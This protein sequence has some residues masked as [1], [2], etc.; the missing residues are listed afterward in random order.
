VQEWI[1]QFAQITN[2]NDVWL[3]EQSFFKCLDHIMQN[4]RM[5]LNDEMED[6]ARH[7]LWLVLSYY[8]AFALRD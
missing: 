7:Q 4:G 3:M 5:I 2:V 6:S 8:P 1:V